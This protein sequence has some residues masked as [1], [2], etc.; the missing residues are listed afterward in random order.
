M[1]RKSVLLLLAATCLPAISQPRP[2]PPPSLRLYIFDCGR[3]KVDDPSRFNFKKEELAT[4][5]FAVPCYLI[6]HPKGSMMWDTGVVPD[7][8]FKPGGGPATKEYATAT[9]PL[10]SQL[11]AIGYAPGDIDYLALSHYHWDHVANAYLFV[12]AT[13]LVTKVERD[14]MFAATLPARTNPGMFS[15]LRD[16][17]TVILNGD[18]DVFGDGTVVIKPAPGHTPGHQ[19][20]F[21]K[22]VKTG[23]VLLSGDL[24]HYPEERSAK[25]VPSADF[26][27]QQTAASRAAIEAFLKTTGARLWIQHDLA[28]FNK[29]KKAPSFYD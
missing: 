9:I 3:L 12:K 2:A 27:P 4:L 13:W 11:A 28:A 23:P 20:L 25:R 19:V 14:A 29:L 17:K 6:A 1:N 7:N 22:L 21:L 26:D 16:A 15:A 5:D 18:Y 10:T 24:Y 8:A